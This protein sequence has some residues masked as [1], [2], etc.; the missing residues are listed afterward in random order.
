MP[1]RFERRDRVALLTLDDPP[2]N[3][4]DTATMR[5]LERAWSEFAEDEELWVAI[6]TGAGD[7]YFCAG[8]DLKTMWQEDVLAERRRAPPK[9]HYQGETA[10]QKPIIAAINGPALG[11]GLSMALACDLKVAAAHATFGA[12]TVRWGMIAAAASQW[13]PRLVPR[14][15]ALE[16]LYTGRPLG[17]QRAY[18]IGLVNRVVPGER[19]MDEALSLADEICA[20]APLAVWAYKELVERGLDLPFAEGVALASTFYQ[21]LLASAD[22]AEGRAAFAQKRRPHWQAR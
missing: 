15:V 19:L 16:V 18:E 5:A 2:L 9:M 11:G 14:A 8:A 12:S 21:R 7:R 10:V 6:L 4:Y 22:A 17:A 13:L 20:A 3:L 1:L